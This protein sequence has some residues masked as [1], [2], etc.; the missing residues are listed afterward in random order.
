M[1][2]LLGPILFVMDVAPQNKWA[3]IA[4]L[5]LLLP[6]MALVLFHRRIWTAV[7]STL[8]FLLWIFFG[9]IGRGINA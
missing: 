7:V 8:A 9:I 6:S 2:I 4:L 1:R 5:I 3:G